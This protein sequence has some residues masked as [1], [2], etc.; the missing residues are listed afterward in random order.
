M[1]ISGI[2]SSGTNPLTPQ[3]AAN[4]TNPAATNGRSGQAEDSGTSRDRVEISATARA[5]AGPV[6]GVASTS[7]SAESTPTLDADRVKAVLSRVDTGFYDNP[8]I[9]N[10]VAGR[11]LSDLQSL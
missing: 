10:I 5:L 3:Q 4:N 11:T 9:Q 1:G 2:N 7:S 6:D 8:A